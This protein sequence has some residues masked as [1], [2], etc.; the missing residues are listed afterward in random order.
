MPIVQFGAGES[1]VDQT[2]TVEN[3]NSPMCVEVLA[4]NNQ[5]VESREIFTVSL[6]TND[7]AVQLPRMTSSLV[8]FDDDCE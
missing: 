8:V 4:V 1:S 5:I 6:T 3:Q 7:L 2:F